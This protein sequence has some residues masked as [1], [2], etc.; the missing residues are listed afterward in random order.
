MELKKEFENIKTAD[1]CMAFMKTYLKSYTTLYSVA[2]G[3]YDE[4]SFTK[5][6]KAYEKDGKYVVLITNLENQKI[7]KLTVCF[8]N[9]KPK[10]PHPVFPIMESFVQN[11][12]VYNFVN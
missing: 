4:T 7:S 2:Y 3:D 10:K 1:E 6:I 9:K 8:S 5:Q 11:P 12:L